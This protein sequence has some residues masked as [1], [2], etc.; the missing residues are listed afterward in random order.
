MTRASGR[1]A[2]QHGAS[3]EAW[4]E[5]QHAEGMRLGLLAHIEHN[6]AQARMVD[7]RLMYTSKGVADY[8]GTLCDGFGRSLAVECKST[9]KSYLSKSAVSGL[10]QRHL[11]AVALA[12][13]VSILLVELQVKGRFRRH[14]LRWTAAP[15]KV[16][17]TVESVS[18]EDI[19]L[20][21]VP[22]D[23]PCYLRWFS[24]DTHAKPGAFGRR[25]VFP[26]D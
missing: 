5:R 3:L 9:E 14:A 19:E 23:E 7:G 6:Q 13:G 8:T 25:H 2:Q 4:A 21:I 16:K 1:A 11:D 20:F 24:D 26:R 10:Q 15:W 12:G 18:A 17:R 22:V